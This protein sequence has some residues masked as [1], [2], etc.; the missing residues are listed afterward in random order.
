ME[1]CAFLVCL[2]CGR[3]QTLKWRE[4]TAPS[5]PQCCLAD[6]HADEFALFQPPRPCTTDPATTPAGRDVD[7]GERST[8]R[9]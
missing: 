9:E 8:E 4:Q 1:S 2:Y 7:P 5:W 6:M 3:R